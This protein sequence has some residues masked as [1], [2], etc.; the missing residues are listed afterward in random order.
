MLTVPHHSTQ[1]TRT[2][3]VK[4]ERPSAYEVHQFTITTK[5]FQVTSEVTLCF[6]YSRKRDK[7]TKNR[8]NHPT[9]TNSAR[10]SLQWPHEPRGTTIGRKRPKNRSSDSGGKRPVCRHRGD[11]CTCIWSIPK[12][13]SSFYVC[14]SC[15]CFVYDDYMARLVSRLE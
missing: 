1:T 4:E 7:K 13:I 2:N 9:Q 12:V 10:P 11:P 6:L 15:M 3:V 5:L 8:E 14:L